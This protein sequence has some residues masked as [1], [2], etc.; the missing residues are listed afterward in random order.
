MLLYT[1][2]NSKERKVEWKRC[3]KTLV[4]SGSVMNSQSWAHHLSSCVCWTFFI[5]PADNSVVTVLIYELI[6]QTFFKHTNSRLALL[7][8]INCFSNMP[9]CPPFPPARWLYCASFAEWP[10]PTPFGCSRRQSECGRSPRE[11]RGA[12]GCPDEGMQKEHVRTKCHLVTPVWEQVPFYRG[13]N[14]SSMSLTHSIS[15]VYWC[16]GH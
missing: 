7:E 10:D 9:V 16:Q 6:Q 12:R 2:E 13:T 1:K 15:N 5:K 3:R 8:S 4:I 14:K 11:P